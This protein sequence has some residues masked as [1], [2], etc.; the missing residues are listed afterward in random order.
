MTRWL[1]VGA[2]PGETAPVLRA[3]VGPR[4]IGARLVIGRLAGVPVGVLTCG[5][6]AR[7][8]GSRT[9]VALR[10]W[11]ADGVLSFGTCGALTDGLV[12][13]AVVSGVAGAGAEDEGAPAWV[14][15][16]WP[17][18]LPARVATVRRVVEDRGR[19][20]ALAA[21]GYSVCEM[22]AAGVAAAAGHRVFGALKVVS[23]HAG[24]DA[25]FQR[26]GPD[27]RAWLRFQLRAAR[28]VA[29]ALLPALCA[30]IANAG[31]NW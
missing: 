14:A 5:V 26:W 19:R 4:P 6:G 25:G 16:P 3:L 1:L 7:S 22:E 20:A 13:G 15:P 29:E 17:G 21:C 30:R 24:A 11:T 23:D 8:A 31:P 9:A 10:R 2:L 27:P 12:V 28:L 18:V